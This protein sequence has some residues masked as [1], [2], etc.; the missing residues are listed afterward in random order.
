MPGVPEYLF[1]LWTTYK[2]PQQELRGWKVGAG[3]NWRASSAYPGSVLET[4]AYWLASSMASYEHRFAGYKAIVQLNVNNLLN[5]FYYN[6]L[7]L[8]LRQNYA[9]LNYGDP[10]EY[11]LSLRVEF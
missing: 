9:D 2:L 1:N 8:A 11:R 10:R 7:Y 6:D 5:K 4:P 3:A